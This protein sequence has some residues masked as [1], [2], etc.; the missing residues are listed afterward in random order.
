MVE[1]T[2]LHV[3]NVMA[4]QAGV[5]AIS[6]VTQQPSSV[7]DKILGSKFGHQV[8]FVKGVCDGIY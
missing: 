5:L 2:W 6:A 1:V 8:Q 4:R 3:T 7:Y